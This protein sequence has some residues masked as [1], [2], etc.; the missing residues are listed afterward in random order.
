MQYDRLTFLF[1]ASLEMQRICRRQLPCPFRPMMCHGA[2]QLFF[3][4]LVNPVEASKPLSRG[5]DEFNLKVQ[6]YVCTFDRLQS[7]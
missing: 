5:R 6:I 2:L 4:D 1:Q 3:V 7:L